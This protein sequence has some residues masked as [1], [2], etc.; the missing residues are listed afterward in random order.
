[1]PLWGSGWEVSVQSRGGSGAD[2]SSLFLRG[3]RSR[4]PMG[5]G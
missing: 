5:G 2:L 4:G 1:M 3:H